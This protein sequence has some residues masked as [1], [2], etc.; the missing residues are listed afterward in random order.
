VSV[1]ILLI[2]VLSLVVKYTLEFSDRTRSPLLRRLRRARQSAQ[3]RRR[4]AS[5]SAASGN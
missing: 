1:E 5:A 3:A 2:V 4:A